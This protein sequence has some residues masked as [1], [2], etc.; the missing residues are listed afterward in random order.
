MARK[1]KPTGQENWTWDEINLG[2]RMPR[3]ARKWYRLFRG[4][5]PYRN[6]YGNSPRSE[7]TRSG[8]LIDGEFKNNYYS[9]KDRSILW[10]I[11]NILIFLLLL[12]VIYENIRVNDYENRLGNLV[13]SIHTQAQTFN[14][15]PT[16]VLTTSNT[17][18]ECDFISA[19][20]AHLGRCRRLA[21][22]LWAC[23][24]LSRICIENQ[25]NA[26]FS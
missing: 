21:S 12:F 5:H 13:G 7:Q 18:I 26:Y 24:K 23:N 6:L 11:I 15:L 20:S 19:I 9:R 2:Y 1:R 16:T 25:T 8:R 17:S 10:I 14:S 3:T 4:G 22:K